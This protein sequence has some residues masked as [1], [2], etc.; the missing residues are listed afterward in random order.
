MFTPRRK[1]E[2]RPQQQKVCKTCGKLFIRRIYWNGKREAWTQFAEREYCSRKCHF[3]HRNE[4]AH[5]LLK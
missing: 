2:P 5:E 1:Q 3:A 4:I